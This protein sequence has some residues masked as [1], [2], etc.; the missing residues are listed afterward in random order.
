[1]NQERRRRATQGRLT[2][3]LATA[4]LAVRAALVVLTA[5]VALIVS[6]GIALAA[7]PTA[8]PGSGGDVRTDPAAPGLVGDPLFAVLGVA[9]IAVVA[10]AATL[11]AIRLADRR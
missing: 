6:A 1:V 3:R 4:A 2:A 10:V 5:T 11:V 7:D 8:S 9:V